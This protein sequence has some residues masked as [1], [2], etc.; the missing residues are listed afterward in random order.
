MQSYT[1][2]ALLSLLVQFLRRFDP[3]L[4]KDTSPPDPLDQAIVPT[5][6][7]RGLIART[8][9]RH[10][11]GVLL[12]VGQLLPDAED[13]PVATVLRQGH[14][15]N[16][17]AQKWMRL[18]RYYHSDCR[19]LISTAAPGRW[20]CH[21]ISTLAPETL[22]E[23]CLIAGVLFGLIAEIGHQPKK[24]TIG[25]Q[26]LHPN[27]FAGA[28]F[29]AEE[30]GNDFAI[31]WSEKA[32][33]RVPSPI[34][35][36][37]RLSD[38]LADLLARDPGRSW[39]IDDAAKPLALSR[40]SL[41]RHLAQEGRSFSS[42]LRRARL[43]EATRLLCTTNT[44][45]ADIGYCCGYADQAHFQREFRRIANTTPRQFRQIAGA[46]ITQAGV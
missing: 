21:R 37:D 38:Q 11:A 30:T 27:A 43:R 24:I 15:P 39:R 32:P 34:R 28:M 22:G 31:H 12:S 36:P 44:G 41:Q 5:C 1:S 23:N 14:D 29:Q 35:Q 2:T 25:G 40:R 17:T 4:V 19:T 16:A 9:A 6:E 8:V 3:D 7:K 26:V 46:G 42:T 10:G 45:L 18:E 13:T 33:C 20:T